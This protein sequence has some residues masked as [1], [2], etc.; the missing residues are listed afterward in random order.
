[1]ATSALNML[2]FARKLGLQDISSARIDQNPQTVL[3]AADLSPLLPALRPATGLYG[4]TVPQVALEFAKVFVTAVDPGGLI[5]KAANLQPNTAVGMLPIGTPVPAGG[6]VLAPS[7]VF[8]EDPTAAGP[9]SVVTFNTDP[10]RIFTV[11]LVGLFA[12]FNQLDA[13]AASLVIAKGRTLLFE[14]GVINQIMAISLL[15]QAVP[16]AS[17]PV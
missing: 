16:V 17:G 3:V 15:L 2:E 5:I 9:Q 8:S 12:P 6:T 10:V 4:T 14:N 11:P 7:A 13:A 1:M